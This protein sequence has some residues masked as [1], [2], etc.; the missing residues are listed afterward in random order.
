MKKI[1]KFGEIVLF[2]FLC[3]S[4]VNAVKAEERTFYATDLESAP[5][6][7]GVP[8]NNYTLDNS[9]LIIIKGTGFGSTEDGLAGPYACWGGQYHGGIFIK[10]GTIYNAISCQPFN[11]NNQPIG[12][13]FVSWDDSEI[14]FYAPSNIPNSAYLDNAIGLRIYDTYNGSQLNCKTVSLRLSPICSSF[15]YSD[16]S[17]CSQN[18]MQTRNILNSYPS[19][20][21]DGGPMLSQSCTPDCTKNDYSCGDWSSCSVDGNQTRICTKIS[22]CDGGIQMPT[23]SQNCTYVPPTCSSWTY[24]SW[25]DCQPNS[26]QTRNITNSFPD[27]C[28]GG[29]P[30][31]SQSCTYPPFC[32]SNDWHCTIWNTCSSDGTQT[33][34]C[35]KVSNCQNGVS[36]PTISQSC[37]FQCTEDTWECG[38]WGTC[39]SYG[40]Q[41]RSCTMTNNCYSVYTA[42][43]KTSQSCVYKKSSQSS[44]TS[45]SFAIKVPTDREDGVRVGDKVYI[46]SLGSG[47]MIGDVF[48]NNIKLSSVTTYLNSF[49]V[50]YKIY[51]TQTVYFIVP[52][53]AK[54][55][56]LMIHDQN[57]KSINIGSINIYEPPIDCSLYGDKAHYSEQKGDCYCQWGYKWNSNKTGCIEDIKE[58]AKPVILN[59]TD[60]DGVPN[61]NDYYPNKKSEVIT[62]NYNFN[63]ILTGDNHGKKI[64]IRI[65]IPKDLYLYYQNQNHIFS[66]NFRN[67][68][69]FITYDDLVIKKIANQIKQLNITQNFN[70]IAVAYQLVSQI[71]YTSDK[72][73]INGWDEYP[74]YPIETI[75]EGSGDCEDTT[76]LMASLL[77]AL[78]LGDPSLVRFDNHLG[79]AAF[80]VD[81]EN[82]GKDIFYIE[83]TGN[84]I[85]HPGVMPE[86]LVGKKYTLHDLDEYERTKY[87]V[88]KIEVPAREY[89]NSEKEKFVFPIRQDGA[90]VRKFS[91]SGIYLI[92]NGNKRPIKSAKI[93]L[94]KGYKWGDV[95]EISQAEMNSYPLGTDLTMDENNENKEIPSEQKPSGT[96]SNGALVRAKGTTGIYLINDNQ[97]R[98]IRSTEIFLAKG[99]KWSDVVDIEHSVLDVYPLGENIVLSEIITIENDTQIVTINVSK[100]R[101]RSLPSLDGKIISLVSEGRSYSVIFEQ[102]GWYKIN[103][104]TDKTGW[105]MSRYVAKIDKRDNKTQK[106]EALKISNYDNKV[107]TIKLN[108]TSDNKIFPNEFTVM[109]NEDLILS[110]SSDSKTPYICGLMRSMYS[111]IKIGIS[112]EQ[113]KSMTYYDLPEGNYSFHCE[114]KIHNNHSSNISVLIHAKP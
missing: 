97:K 3:L 8:L 71:V 26:M 60:G 76:F 74:K 55:G 102:N 29:N 70:P 114:K 61:N 28:V 92:E 34:T 113:N 30:I 79:L 62:I 87:S 108:I 73:S 38:N 72:F 103:Y 33:R 93:F 18:G 81:N 51:F 104:S 56:N 85:H 1:K 75:I 78:D 59:D 91:T 41:R 99:Y 37:I 2:L 14:K 47:Y 66:E 82:I 67:I 27:S 110:L 40:T 43:P 50:L 63:Y 5:C 95:A 53:N 35:D 101:V 15:T 36:S 11:V 32:T 17:I 84:G 86:S 89:N 21:S 48:L 39:F 65:E 106:E 83:T 109:A 57:G 54:N 105:I 25:S 90:L 19:G 6:L 23:T 7:A 20:C 100:L 107:K 42:S 24:S 77:K 52:E 111:E 46:E 64:D 96:L 69:S 49:M 112:A 22:N 10:N 68:T 13:S 45:D 98:P 88:S 44:K 58:V 12:T 9:D 94:A 31:L 16:W 80:V 4:F